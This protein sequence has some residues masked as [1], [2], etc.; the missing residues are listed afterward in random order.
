[1]TS[2]LQDAWAGGPL[3][4]TTKALFTPFLHRKIGGLDHFADFAVSSATNRIRAVGPDSLWPPSGV[5][6]EGTAISSC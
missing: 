3:Q 4:P 6:D 2:S 1:M 5:L